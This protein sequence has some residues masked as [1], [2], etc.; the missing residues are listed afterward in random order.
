MDDLL[1]NPSI[2]N[3]IILFL[4][5]S[6]SL[7]LSLFQ[8]LLLAMQGAQRKA[9]TRLPP[10]IRTIIKRVVLVVDIIRPG[11]S[12]FIAGNSAT[13]SVVR[14]NLLAFAIKYLSFRD[15]FS[16]DILDVLSSLVNELSNDS[17]TLPRLQSSDSCSL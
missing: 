1:F 8:V 3:R 6:L 7:S 11:R 15:A 12:L 10:R 13:S 16:Q 2:S 4:S 14:P 9:S 5:S 17:I